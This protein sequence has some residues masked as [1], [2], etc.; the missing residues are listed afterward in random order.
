MFEEIIEF[1]E[2]G[3]HSYGS[4]G[5][6]SG[7]FSFAF[8]GAGHGDARVSDYGRPGF[9][10]SAGYGIKFRKTGMRSGIL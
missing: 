9:G 7:S 5:N 3:Y 8:R 1:P 10:S 2:F 4:S 6:G